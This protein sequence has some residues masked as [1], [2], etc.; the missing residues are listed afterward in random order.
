VS[1]RNLRDLVGD[2]VPAEELERLQR[3]HDLLVSAGPP[4][5][6]PESMTDLPEA[7][8]EPEPA[9]PLVMRRRAGVM[10]ALAAALAVAAFG[11]GYAVG[12]RK[13]SF[14]AQG[15]TVLMRG[16]ALA[17]EA[18]AS[19]DLGKTD[20]TG[21]TKLRMR[22]HGLK[23][24][25]GRNYYELYLTNKGKISVTCGTFRVGEGTTEV[26]LSIPYALERYDGWV[27][28]RQR[29]GKPPSERFLLKTRKV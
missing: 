15:R 11:I 1:E 21:N 19:L 12:D 10:I 6:L 18:R 14:E 23:P 16:T 24:V 3:V 25:R 29:V 2:D 7:V 5:E 4:P 8:G 27:V 13:D 28:T 26:I 9:V 20:E 22:V 17:P